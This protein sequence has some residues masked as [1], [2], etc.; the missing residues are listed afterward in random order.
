MLQ[1]GVGAVTLF[2]G[3]SCDTN[4][5]SPLTQT[6]AHWS[7]TTPANDAALGSQVRRESRL[8]KRILLSS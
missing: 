3:F 7:P 8:L 1:L 6:L 4:I 5:Y 2:I